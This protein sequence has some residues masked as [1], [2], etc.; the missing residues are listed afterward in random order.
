MLNELNYEEENFDREIEDIEAIVKASAKP[1]S[2][3]ID[4]F[5]SALGKCK[6]IR[7]S[8]EAQCEVG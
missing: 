6:D 5:R 4:Q 1:G 8:R 2:F 7:Q 3:L